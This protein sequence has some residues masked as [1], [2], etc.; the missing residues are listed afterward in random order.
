LPQNLRIAPRIERIPYVEDGVLDKRGRWTSFMHPETSLLRPG[1]NCSGFVVAAARR[2]LTCDLNLE[3]ITRDR[4]G[5][6]GEGAPLGKDW[7]FGW[8]LLLNLSEGH[9]RRWILPEGTRPVGPE[10]GQSLRGFR[11]Q[12]A[13]AWARI[14]PR[15]K[16]D[17]VYLASLRRTQSG[18]VRHHHVALL[19]LDSV[20]RTWW[21]QT[22]PGGRS[23]RLEISTALGFARLCTMFGPQE[24]I[25]LLEV[26]P[27]TL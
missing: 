13:E 11:V 1:L 27:N 18:R 2:L 16:R 10:D 6:S 23:H 25:L 4:L 5:D 17:R 7:D 3:Q 26:D 22:L 20:G 9:A 14:F 15:M 8:D 24:G 21:Y 12:D 19:L